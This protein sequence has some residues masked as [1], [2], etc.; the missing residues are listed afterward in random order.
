MIHVI[1]VISLSVE[2]VERVEHVTTNVEVS[3][4]FLVND[5]FMCF[6]FGLAIKEVTEA[7]LEGTVIIGD[8]YFIVFH[9]F[10]MFLFHDV[11][12]CYH[13]CFFHDI[14]NALVPLLVLLLGCKRVRVTARRCFRAAL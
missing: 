4:H 5:I 3:M 9:G 1:H 12:N 14:L 11:T 6:F 10:Y 2:H 8:V 13:M 7:P